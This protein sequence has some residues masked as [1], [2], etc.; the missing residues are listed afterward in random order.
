MLSINLNG[1]IDM[2][3]LKGLEVKLATSVECVKVMDMLI[4]IA[5]W[6]KDSGI[7]QWNYLLQGGDNEEIKQ[8]IDNQNT[9]IV[10]VDSEIIATFT[11]TTE[12]SEWDQHIFG[13]DSTNDSLYLHRLAVT[14]EYM[15]QGIGQELL[16]WIEQNHHSEKTYLKLDCVADNPRLNQF[17]LEN[18]FEYIGET[19]N[20]SKYQK[21]LNRR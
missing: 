2:N 4:E 5:Q 16:N 20:H 15:N 12:Q 6:M 7:K 19:D 18:G 21:A 14:P 10:L 13:V 17:Y 11:L 8:A 1:G 9:Y 3:L